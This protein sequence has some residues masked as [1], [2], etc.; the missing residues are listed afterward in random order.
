MNSDLSVK[1]KFFITN[2]IRHIIRVYNVH[3]SQGYLL[4]LKK[5]LSIFD[6]IFLKFCNSKPSKIYLK[7][8]TI[9]GRSINK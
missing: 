9:T 6:Q 4:I 1:Y 2:I 7:N 3:K 5:C 8:K